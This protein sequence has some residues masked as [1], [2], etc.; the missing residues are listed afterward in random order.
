[1]AAVSSGAPPPKNLSPSGDS[2]VIPPG[3]YVKVE[4]MRG[5]FEVLEG[6]HPS[7][8]Y[9]VLSGEL[10]VWS[11]KRTVTPAAQSTKDKPRAI[12]RQKSSVA[13]STRTVDLHALSAAEATALLTTTVD[14]A[15]LDDVGELR[16][17]HGRGTGKVKSAVHKYLRESPHVKRFELDAHNSGVTKAYL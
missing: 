8:G 16:I 2:E 14:R 1:M 13:G 11:G 4:G 17:I 10:K 3:A 15:L 9:L 12:K 6:P 5:A 7:K